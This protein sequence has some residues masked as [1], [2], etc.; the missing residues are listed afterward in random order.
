MK[1]VLM[2]GFGDPD[3]LFIG[4]APAPRLGPGELLVRVRATALNR[5]DLL[6]RRGHYPPPPGASDILGLEIA[7]EVAEVGAGTSGWRI[8]DRVCALLPGGG[9]AQYAVIPAGMAM[10]IPPN[11]SFEQA[12][13]IPEVFLTAYLNLFWLAR[14]AAHDRVLIHAGASG[15]GT[16][17]IQ[18]VREAGGRSWVTAGSTEKIARCLELGAE[19]GW[20]YHDGS[21]APFVAEQTAGQGVDIVLDFVGAPY[22]HDNLRSLA[23]DGRLVVIGTMGGVKVDEVDLGYLLGRRL[24]IIGTALRSRPVAEKMR[25][26]QAFWFFAEERFASARLRPVVDTVFPWTDVVAAHR[27]MEENRNTGKIVLR[28]DS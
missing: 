21:F 27:Y 10:R 19:A 16:A 6:Q 7:G 25:L 17:A 24:Q 23:M 14:F 4:E 26:T 15:V 3:V 18:L 9:Y 2:S 13:A 8:G 20:N 12:A 11:L 28:V 22:F 5:A 1:A